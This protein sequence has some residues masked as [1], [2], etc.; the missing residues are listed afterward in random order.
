M[1]GVPGEERFCYHKNHVNKVMGICVVGYAYEGNPE[2]GG[3]AVKI[4]FTRA[5]ASKIA[6]RMQRAYSGTNA[7]G[8][9]EYRGEVL[10][11]KGDPFSVDTT[12]TGSSEGTSDDPKFALVR[13]FRECVF[14][15]IAALVGTGGAFEGYTPV[16]QGDQAGPHEE[17]EFK[18]FVTEWCKEK[19]WLWEPQAPQMP[20]LNV[21]DLAVFPAMSKR[22][23][24]LTR[25]FTG[26]VASKDVIWNNAVQVWNEM[27]ECVIARA[28][29]LAWRLAAL[30]IE[31]GGENTFLGTKEMHRGVRRD[32]N[33]TKNGVAPKK[34][35]K[36]G[37]KV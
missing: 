36:E 35:N 9:R 15:Q 3:V 23:S 29:V 27:E 28:F 37:G 24:T 5:Q 1:C 10:R 8:G 13:Y 34:K 12:V 7:A 11:R 31:K 22:H 4:A 19:G 20:H 21:D 17:E 33:D 30:V 16:I 26:S 2:K 25:R 32:F 14:K 18:R 6:G